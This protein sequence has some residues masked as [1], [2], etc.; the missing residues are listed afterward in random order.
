MKGCGPTRMDAEEFN[1]RVHWLPNP[2]KRSHD[3]IEA[4]DDKSMYYSFTELFG[5][6]ETNEDDRPSKEK[7]PERKEAAE[8]DKANK[9]SFTREF[10]EGSIRCTACGKN[11]AI[12]LK[13]QQG[14]TQLTGTQRQQLEDISTSEFDKYTC[15]APLFHTESDHPLSKKLVV[16]VK[17]TCITPQLQEMYRG[18]V[19]TCAHCGDCAAEG[20]SLVHN[21]GL[22]N[23]GYK[24]VA[25]ICEW[26]KKEGLPHPHEKK[27]QA[28]VS[29]AVLER[30][31]RVD[32]AAS[33]D[34]MRIRRRQTQPAD[35]E[36]AIVSHNMPRAARALTGGLQLSTRLNPDPTHTPNPN[37]NPSPNPNQP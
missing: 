34:P 11:R 14:M 10:Q 7:D 8:I 21:I 26:C 25:P 37:P 30:A 3:E 22:R 4:S 6:K 12:F 2:T 27:R 17:L 9:K 31:A 20:Q 28:D 1:R 23:A 32:S 18:E 36:G 24:W 15:G 29:A 35:Q 5:K 13:S 33:G 19:E 16:R